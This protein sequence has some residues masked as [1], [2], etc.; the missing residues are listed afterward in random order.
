VFDDGEARGGG[1]EEDPPA[2]CS[3]QQS[4]SN[5]GS[6]VSSLLELQAEVACGPLS[7]EEWDLLLR[8]K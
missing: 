1:P 5:S 3:Q 6:G 2:P 4:L 8:H 7:H